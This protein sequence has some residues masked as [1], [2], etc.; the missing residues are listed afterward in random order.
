LKAGI[1]LE[2][3]PKLQLGQAAGRAAWPRL[4]AAAAPVPLAAPPSPAGRRA[5]AGWLLLWWLLVLQWLPWWVKLLLLLLLLHL[6][7]RL[8]ASIGRGGNG[9]IGR[10][11][12]GWWAEGR[13][14]LQGGSGPGGRARCTAGAEW[15]L[16]SHNLGT[17][18]WRGRRQD[19]GPIPRH[20]QLHPAVPVQ[21]NL[22][23]DE[24]E[25]HLLVT[26]RWH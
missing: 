15:P 9:G 21:Y 24:V 14:V 19:G 5:P 18:G 12:R 3:V 22:P 7:A 8:L 16:H 11:R 2:H 17:S 26:G 20:R 10:G 25:C 6:L 1:G 13:H 4:A 23:F